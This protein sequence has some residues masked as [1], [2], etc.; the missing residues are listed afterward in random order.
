MC[1]LPPM[2]SA[3]ART[4]KMP[5]I[6]VNYDLPWAVIRL[7]QRAG[8]VGPH[9]PAGRN[10]SVPIR[11]CPQVG[12]NASSACAPACGSGS[13]ENAEVVGADEAFFEDDRNDEIMRDLLHGEGWHS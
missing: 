5:A 10:D 11:F 9:W 13:T 1:S 6:V 4:C 3:K 2:C 8:R 7:V 12:W